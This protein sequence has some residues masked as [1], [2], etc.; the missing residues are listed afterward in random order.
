MVNWLW[1][2]GLSCSPDLTSHRLANLKFTNRTPLDWALSWE[3]N[4]TSLP[5]WFAEHWS[6]P[7]SPLEC[8]RCWWICRPR[9]LFGTTF[10]SKDSEHSSLSSLPRNPPSTIRYPS[11]IPGLTCTHSVGRRETHSRKTQVSQENLTL[12]D[13][14]PAY[15]SQTSFRLNLNLCMLRLCHLSLDLLRELEH[16][17]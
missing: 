5:H 1:T 8:R 15:V 13:V 2:S 11:S 16:S 6:S 4:R 10:H 12:E 17:S 14:S 9:A 7:G 3:H